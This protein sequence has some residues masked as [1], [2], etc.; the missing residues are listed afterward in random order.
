MAI[1]VLCQFCFNPNTFDNSRISHS[2]KM[3]P[4]SAHDGDVFSDLF[5]MYVLGGG[6]RFRYDGIMTLSSSALMVI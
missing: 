3:E 2:L 4:R 1:Q 6:Y 5:L